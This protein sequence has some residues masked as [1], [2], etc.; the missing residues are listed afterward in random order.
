[1]H[2][3]KD[4]TLLLSRR[5]GLGEITMCSCGVVALHLGNTTIRLERPVE[6]LIQAALDSLCELAAQA[7]STDLLEEATI[8]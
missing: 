8:Q 2:E 6:Q 3:D 4:N 5:K 7:R 1:M